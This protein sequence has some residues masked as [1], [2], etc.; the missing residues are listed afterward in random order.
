MEFSTASVPRDRYQM[1]SERLSQSAVPE[2]NAAYVSEALELKSIQSPYVNL[3]VWR[4]PV[5]AVMQ[6]VIHWLAKEPFEIEHEIDVRDVSQ[7]LQGHL[8]VPTEFDVSR[9]HLIKDIQELANLFSKHASTSSIRLIIEALHRVPCPKF[10]QDNVTLRLVC[11][12]TGTGTEWLENSN[13]NSH[14][15]C[16]GGSIVLDEARIKN[17]NAFEVGLMKGKR[18]PGNAMGIFHRSPTIDASQPRLVVK[19]DVV[20]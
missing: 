12:Y 4:R 18:W 2:H 20:H 14:P 15:D 13:V 1:D 9:T 8:S 19:M 16:C 11:T 6:P 5:D 3:A 17:L 7:T 10:H